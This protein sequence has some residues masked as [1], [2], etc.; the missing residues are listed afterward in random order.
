MTTAVDMNV[1]KGQAE[2]LLSQ[3]LSATQDL[4]NHAGQ[5]GQV[6]WQ[7]TLDVVRVNCLDNLVQGFL[8]AIWTIGVSIIFVKCM[9]KP[10][11]TP[12]GE[13][14]LPNMFYTG[15]SGFALFITILVGSSNDIYEQLF[16]IWNWVGLW[17]PELY[18]ANEALNKVMGNS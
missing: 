3:A 15:I 4:A 2:D 6:A 17:H 9:G 7:A 18:L 5:I 10:K 12:S 8:L 11:V 14:P 13:H 1:I 16:E